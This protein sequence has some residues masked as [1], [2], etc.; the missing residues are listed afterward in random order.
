MGQLYWGCGRAWKCGLRAYRCAQEAFLEERWSV[1]GDSIHWLGLPSHTG[2]RTLRGLRIV[3]VP[4]I[5][6]CYKAAYVNEGGFCDS[7]LED[8]SLK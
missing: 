5:P 8:S 1:G 4:G 2:P 7:L 6:G 3:I